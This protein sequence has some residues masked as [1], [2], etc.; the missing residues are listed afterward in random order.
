MTVTGRERAADVAR[1]HV[2]WEWRVRRARRKVRCALRNAVCAVLGHSVVT[3]R[4]VE[5]YDEDDECKRCHK[6]LAFRE[7]EPA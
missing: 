6:V 2:G 4:F 3:R 5:S 7:R 1:F